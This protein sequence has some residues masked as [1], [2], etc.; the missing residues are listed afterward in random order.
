M[1]KLIVFVLMALLVVPLFAGGASEST[2]TTANKDT[3][4]FV[5]SGNPFRFFHLTANGCGGDDNIV[6]ANV[7]D[8]LLCLENDGSLTPSLAESYTLSDDGTIYTFNLR[9]GVRFTNGEEMTAEDVKFTLDKGAAGPLGGALLIN[10]KE[11]RII[12]PYTVEV[13]LTSPYA[14]FPYCVASRVGGIACKSYWE[15]VGDEGYQANPV[16]TGPYKLVGY[17]A[18]DYVTLEANEDHWRGAPAIKTVQIELVADT[19][20]MILGLQNGD[21]DV[22]A[23][24]SIDMIQRFEKDP[25]I[26]TDIANSTGRITLYLQAVSG[27]T[28]DVNF[29]K[30]VQYAIDK[31]EVNI[32]VN[33][34]AATLIDVD[35]C[36]MYTGH[37]TSGLIKVEQDLDKAREYLKAANYNNEPF[38]ILCQAGTNYETAAKVLQA[39]LMKVGINCKVDA[40][41]NTT[42]RTRDGARDFDSYLCDNLSSIPDADA[43]AG[44]FKPTRFP[45]AV[46]YP[47]SAEIYELSLKGCAS[48]AGER[49]QYYT[50]ICNI[51][52]EEAYMVPLYNGITTIAYNSELD[53]VGS[54]CLN[55]YLFRYWNWK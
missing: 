3:V 1:K 11:C 44:F 12:D 21:Y 28:A 24:P 34:G 33:N 2:A 41:D 45:A 17:A 5:V 37:P 13:E 43:I 39:Q 50:E 53:G 51:T 52:T 38:S 4:T 30:A 15:E 25:K 42:V 55:Y 19:N 31:E 20:T 47:R 10:Y 26:S 40:V 27:I 49:E 9:K 36:P 22:M 14:A 16:G 35:L 8:N 48:P 54:H 7:Y 18:N 6:L 32:A 29:R 23:N 46:Q